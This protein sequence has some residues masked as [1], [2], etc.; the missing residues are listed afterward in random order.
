MNFH[1]DHEEAQK[2]AK[3]TKHKVGTRET[4]KDNQGPHRTT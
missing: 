2:P 1:E 3:T 4:M